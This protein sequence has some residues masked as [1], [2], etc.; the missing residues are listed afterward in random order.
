MQISMR[1]WSIKLIVFLQVIPSVS[2]VHE[3]GFV[4]IKEIEFKML[5]KNYPISMNTSLETGCSHLPYFIFKLSPISQ[6]VSQIHESVYPSC[7]CVLF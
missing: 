4:K 7:K 1:M 2:N 3:I 6:N 5:P